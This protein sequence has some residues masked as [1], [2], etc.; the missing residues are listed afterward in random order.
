VAKHGAVLLTKAS[1]LPTVK[2]I[3]SHIRRKHRFIA[4]ATARL[5]GQPDNRYK[6]FSSN[7]NH[8]NNNRRPFWLI[9]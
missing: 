6:L 8:N 5:A 9:G 2:P 4:K 1:Y 7:A 3:A